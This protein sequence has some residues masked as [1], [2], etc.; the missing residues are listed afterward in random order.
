MMPFYSYDVSHSCG[1]DPKV[2]CQFDFKRMYNKRMACPWKIQPKPITD[3]NVAERSKMLLEQYK[4]KAMLY[5]TNNLLV[6]LGDDFRQIFL[7]QIFT[8]NK[9]NTNAFQ[10]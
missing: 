1:P 10:F 7:L 3:D 4:K 6:P 8:L 5:K 9:F 2:C